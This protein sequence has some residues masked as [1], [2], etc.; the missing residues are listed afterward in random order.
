[1]RASSFMVLKPGPLT[2]VQDC[3]RKGYM[4]WGVPESGAADR[5]SL[6]A[7]NLLVGNPVTSA[8]L[9]ITLGGFRAQFASPAVAA[10]FGGSC[11]MTLDAKPVK[12]GEALRVD[13][14][15]IL[16]I[17]IISKGARI[18]LAVRG[19]IDVPEVLGSRATYLKASLGGYRGRALRAG[20][21]L[22]CGHSEEGIPMLRAKDGMENPSLDRLE[23]GACL[24][25]IIAGT[26]PE[27]FEEGALQKLTG[28]EYVVSPE[29]DR[30]G[31]RLS[32][33]AIEHTRG[34]DILSG[35][36]ETGAVQVPGS[37]LPIILMADRQTTGG[38]TKICSVISADRPKL[39]QLRPS[40]RIRFS[41]VD[42]MKAHEVH[43]RQERMLNGLCIPSL[44]ARRF[45]LVI[46]GEAFAVEVE[47]LV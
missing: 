35:G 6:R 19:G 7:A 28:G 45:S 10:L 3:G 12:A 24:L 5:F 32:G 1:M 29:C 25:R 47:E 9:E 36:I 27:R 4:A 22:M 23:D 30:M 39:G 41:V 8:A 44:T 34:A 33:A 21:E 37:G 31:I 18:Y 11:P 43:L 17:G 16:D 40:D 14:G 15:S 20:D 2:T 46:G 26:M 13:A 42:I 38:Y